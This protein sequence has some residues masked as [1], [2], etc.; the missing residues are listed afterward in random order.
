VLDYVIVHEL[1]HLLEPAH[2]TA[3][4]GWVAHY[5]ESEKAKGYL[6]GWSEAAKLPPPPS[7]EELPGDAD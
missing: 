3:F 2:S 5:P 6:L 4:W 7:E 1:A